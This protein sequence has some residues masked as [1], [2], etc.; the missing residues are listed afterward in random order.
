VAYLEKT[1]LK[2]PILEEDARKIK[3]GEV[4]Y[5]TGTLLTARDAAHKRILQY[6]QEGRNLPFTFDGLPLYHCGPLVKKSHEGWTVL[7]AG[8]TT[9]M[10][11]EVFE[12][13]LIRKLG[14]RLIIGKGGMGR[15]TAE[16]MKECGA[17]YGAFTGGT[18]VLAAKHIKK[19][20]GVQWLDLGMAEAVWS[21]EV[22]NFGP[23]IVCMDSYGNNLYS[24]VQKNA[25]NKKVKIFGNF[26]P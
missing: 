21:F 16:S 20:N 7:A 9:S 26:K 19:V 4:V 18:A 3:V 24:K 17:V 13:V 5:V 2:T 25:E 1:E 6:L 23:L 15:K 22:E 8:P 14:V 10:R 12:A 11:M